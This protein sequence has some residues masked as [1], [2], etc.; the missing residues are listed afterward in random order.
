MVKVERLKQM[1]KCA[2]YEEND[3]RETMPVSKYRRRDF[4]SLNMFVTFITSTVAFALVVGMVAVYLTETGTDLSTLDF[5]KLGVLG[6]VLYAAWEVG[7]LMI[8]FVRYRRKYFKAKRSLKGYYDELV[9][10][11]DM[12]KGERV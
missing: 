12:Y 1:T 9:K 11:N 10:L 5:T 6:I 2:I 8:T 7:F 3:G 4:V